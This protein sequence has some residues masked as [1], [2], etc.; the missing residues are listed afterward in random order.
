MTPLF[1]VLTPF[2]KGHGDS[3]N[4]C[5]VENIRDQLYNE[6][7]NPGEMVGPKAEFWGLILFESGLGRCWACFWVF[8]YVNP[9]D[10]PQLTNRLIPC[11]SGLISPRIPGGPNEF[12]GVESSRGPMK[13]P[14]HTW[15][16]QEFSHSACD[17]GRWKTASSLPMLIESHP[18]A[19]GCC[20][21]AFYIFACCDLVGNPDLTAKT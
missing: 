19:H 20:W 1:R 12:T 21:E 11:K 10:E 3:R 13:C 4:K 9:I 18:L 7:S 8:S 17:N 16:R 6:T 15:G 14:L 5:Q 2:F